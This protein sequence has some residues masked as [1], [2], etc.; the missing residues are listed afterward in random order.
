MREVRFPA[1]AVSG[2]GAANEHR[3]RLQQKARGRSPWLKY[4]GTTFPFWD[5][6]LASMRVSKAPQVKNRQ[7]EW[8]FDKD[9]LGLASRLQR[10]CPPQQVIDHG[11]GL[12]RELGEPLVHVATLEMR[13]KSR[14]GNVEGRSN[15][16]DLNLDHGFPELLDASRAHRAA[17]APKGSG[18]AVPLWINQIDSVL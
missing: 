13:P 2:R 3:R 10:C 5:H 14:S 8:D 17:V 11:L 12:R 18:F 15:R 6:P 1:L 16:R 4:Y 9:G 7:T